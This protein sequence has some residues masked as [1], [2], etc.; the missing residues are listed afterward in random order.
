MLW[1]TLPWYLKTKSAGAGDKDIHN[2]SCI[3]M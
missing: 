3:Y 1:S 2:V